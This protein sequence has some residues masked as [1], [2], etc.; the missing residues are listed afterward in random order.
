MNIVIFLKDGSKIL[1]VNCKDL[2]VD[3]SG[4]SFKASVPPNKN[5]ECTEWDSCVFFYN[6]I[7][8]YKVECH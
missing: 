6:N 7:A 2:L 1:F 3:E 8:G 5:G 4:I